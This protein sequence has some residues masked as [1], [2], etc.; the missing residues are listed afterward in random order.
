MLFYSYFKTLVG[1]QV[2]DR[3]EQRLFESSLLDLNKIVT[4]GRTKRFAISL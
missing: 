3:R 2:C 4:K 1:K